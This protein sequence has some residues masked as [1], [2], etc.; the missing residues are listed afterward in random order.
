[1][2]LEKESYRNAKDVFLKKNQILQ[3]LPE[4]FLELSKVKKIIFKGKNLKTSYIIDIVHSLLLKY[5]FKRDNIF[6]LSSLV[7]RSKYGQLYNYYIDYLKDQNILILKKNY[8]KGKNSKIYALSDQ[9]FLQKILR[10]QNTDKILLKKY[11]NKHLKFE[12][13]IN[14]SIKRPVKTKLIDDLYSVNIDTDRSLFYLD[15]LKNEDIDVYNRNKYSIESINQNHIFYHFDAYGR[16]HT[17]FTILKSFIRKNCLL[18]NGEETTELDIQNSQP[19]FLF[20]LIKDSDILV[21]ESEFKVFSSLVLNGNYY[22]YFVDKLGLNNKDEAKKL[23]YKVFFG[24]NKSK[25]DKQFAIL[26]PSIFDF[27]IKYKN[28]N[29]KIL[30]HDLQRFESNFIFNTIISRIMNSDKDIRII[31][32]HDSIIV[33]KKWKKIVSDIFFDEISKYFSDKVQDI[34]YIKYD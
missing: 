28:G 34:E 2:I 24:R 33:Q 15:S 12:I 17:N 9:V 22:Q 25:F 8:F 11:Q 32:I 10:Y 13:E 29:Y 31:T 14:N 18:I 4:S 16:M 19:L 30:A 26:F 6:I 5:Y 20:K 23:T 7:L 27:I 1:M 21:N 3:F